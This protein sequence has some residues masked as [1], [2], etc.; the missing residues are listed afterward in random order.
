VFLKPHHRRREADRGRGPEISRIREFL[1][2]WHHGL[3]D[4]APASLEQD[5]AVA[6]Y[7]N[8]KAH[9]ELL[10]ALDQMMQARNRKRRQN[11]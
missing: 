7:R 8:A 6:R 3:H 4:D 1:K 9:D 10:E 5:L 11:G 2:R